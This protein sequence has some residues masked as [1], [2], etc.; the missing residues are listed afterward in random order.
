MCK[1]D[2]H[3]KFSDEK[4]AVQSRV[5]N[6]QVR[7]GNLLQLQLE[8]RISSLGEMAALQGYILLRFH[9]KL[10]LSRFHSPNLQYFLTHSC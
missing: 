6:S 1:K 9:H 10:H 8:Y 7:V 4:Q 3:K 2:I 5:A